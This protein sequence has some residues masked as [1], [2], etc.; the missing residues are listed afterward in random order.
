MIQSFRIALLF[1]CALFCILLRSNSYSIEVESRSSE[2]FI[3]ST[4]KG[5]HCSGSFEILSENSAPIQVNVKG[6]A[7][8]SEVYFDAKFF[9]E[10]L[11]VFTV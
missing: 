11:I 8:V 7:P 3:L 1:A 6:P 10:L 9:G 5:L 2:C 4:A